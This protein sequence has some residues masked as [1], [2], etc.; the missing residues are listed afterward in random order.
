MLA[1]KSRALRRPVIE[2]KFGA[3]R[4]KPRKLRHVAFGGKPLPQSMVVAIKKNG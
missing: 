2:K 4:R 1:R 3:C